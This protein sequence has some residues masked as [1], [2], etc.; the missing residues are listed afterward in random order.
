MGMA[1][2]NLKCWDAF[3][4]SH[5]PLPRAVGP[6]TVVRTTKLITSSDKVMMFCTSVNLDGLWRALGCISS[7]NEGSAMSAAT[8]AR[9]HKVPFPGNELIGSGITA[10]PSALSVQ[11]MNPGALNTTNGI[12]AGTVSHAQLNL[13]GR[14]GET[15]NDFATSVI[16]FMRPRLMS[17][18][19]LALKGVQADSYPLNMAALA[20][21][22]Q[23]DA[24]SDGAFTWSSDGGV[25]PAGFAPIVFV[26]E[27]KTS[28]NYL[29][30]I[31]WRVR[32]DIGN[33]AVASHT[34]HGISSDASWAGAIE[35]MIN[36]GHGIV[37]IADR[38]ADIG[39]SVGGLAQSVARS[40]GM[41]AIA[42]F[43]ANR[44]LAIG[45]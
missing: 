28:M 11:V 24:S 27:A 34:N 20:N 15:W 40:R 32:F 2:L 22:E 41:R 33:P 44:T 16:S 29:V 6:Y 36:R 26:N 9:A 17:A 4:P 5:A 45:A 42:N 35:G 7:V 39:S 43:A 3:H 21:F 19:K 12:F 38:V 23:V 1:R 8:N 18:G 14:T 30:T 25:Y 31:E 37:D 10:V 13:A